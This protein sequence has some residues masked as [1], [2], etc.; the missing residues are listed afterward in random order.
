MMLIPLAGLAMLLSNLLPEYVHKP[1]L[2][3]QKGAYNKEISI[4][5]QN[6][7]DGGHKQL[8]DNHANVVIFCSFVW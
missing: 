3:F 5:Y 2:G 6:P 7:Q 1:K 4:F 8:E